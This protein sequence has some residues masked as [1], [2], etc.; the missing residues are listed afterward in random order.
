MSLA[1]GV[2]KLTCASDD[3]SKKKKLEANSEK[4]EICHRN[5][6]LE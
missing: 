2:G 3:I 4:E 5:D 6:K 1:F